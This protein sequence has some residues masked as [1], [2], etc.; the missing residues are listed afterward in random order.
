MVIALVLFIMTIPSEAAKK[1]V[2]VMHIDNN[3]DTVQTSSE[4]IIYKLVAENMANQLIATFHDSD[5][6]AV[7]DR[8]KVNQALTEAGIKM[9]GT[10]EQDQAISIGK[11]VNAQC[12]VIGKIISAEV[13]ENS[14]KRAL[15]AIKNITDQKSESIEEG[16]EVSETSEDTKTTNSVQIEEFEGKI[17]VELKF[18]NNDTGEVIFSDEMSTSQGGKTGATALRSACKVVAE[19]FISQIAK[20]SS[21]ENKTE[22]KNET[23]QQ[24]STEETQ[25]SDISVI[26]VDG[27][28]LYID[29]GKDANIKVGDIFAIFKKG[30]PIT[31]MNGKVIT[32]RTVEIGKALVTEVNNNHSICKI[33]EKDDS[34]ANAIKRGCTAKKIDE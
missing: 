23:E 28:I 14:E 7:I 25:S 1:N 13:V 19:D 33:I 24:S 3:S 20:Q 10:I 8:E 12:S 17:T 21:L 26:Y 31:D 11:K 5:S 16:K 2:A 18:L 6:Y 30:V 22:T 27:D 32:V 4:S 34:E 9:G 15:E 29:K